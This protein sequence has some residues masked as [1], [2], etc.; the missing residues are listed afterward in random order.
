MTEHNYTIALGPE[1]HPA[2]PTIDAEFGRVTV[3]L[4]AN[5]TGKSTALRLLMD[6]RQSF[7]SPLRHRVNV[8]GGRVVTLPSSLRL[9]QRNFEQFQEHHNPLRDY[10]NNQRSQLS[11]R[12][13]HGLVVLDRRADEFKREHSDAVTAWT[14]GGAEGSL[15]ECA[16]P[17][18]TRLFTMFQNVF[19]DISLKLDPNGRNLRCH[20]NGADYQPPQLSDGERQV[21]SLLADIAL[22]ADPRSLIVVDE[23]EL[24]LHPSLACRLWDELEDQF[25]DAVFVYGTHCLSFALRSNVEKVL[26]LGRAGTQALEMSGIHDLDPQE[27]REFLGAIPAILTAPA[28]LAIEGTENSVDRIVYRWLL[29]RPDVAVVPLAGCEDVVAA[30][31]RTGIWNRLAPQAKVIGVIDRDHR[32]DTEIERLSGANRVVLEFHEIESYLCHPDVVHATAKAVGGVDPIPTVE[33]VREMIAEFFKAQLL[34]TVGRRTCSRLG[35]TL[36][37]GVAGSTL[38]RFTDQDRLKEHIVSQ[39]EE[40]RKKGEDRLRRAFVEKIFDDE[41]GRCQRALSGVDVDELLRLAPGKELLRTLLPLT[42]LRTANGYAR[43][44]T[45]HVDID[46]IDVLSALR[47]DLR[48][49]LP[50]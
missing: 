44:V 39:A 4:G 29:S 13:A 28:A 43:A 14:Q 20:K 33:A 38:K 50:E 23:P 31:A 25:P 8:E 19:P 36:R 27:A 1:K 18:L 22:L 17:P 30:T 12:I 9:D 7:G 37:V 15:P 41:L 35:V 49:L 40:Q 32:S 48:R 11:A 45:E 6:L 5:G 3:L 34:P 10:Q 21:L 2:A 46:A 47:S 24:N 26:I 42:G 16:E